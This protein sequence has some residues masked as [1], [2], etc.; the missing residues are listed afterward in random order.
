METK[1]TEV[2]VMTQ[3]RHDVDSLRQALAD[4]LEDP[5]LSVYWFNQLTRTK[6]RIVNVRRNRAQLHVKVRDDWYAVDDDRD[7][8][9]IE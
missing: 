7:V 9:T 5:R 2:E 1:T 3:I 4:T 6:D 8:F